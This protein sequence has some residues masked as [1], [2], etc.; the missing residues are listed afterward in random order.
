MGFANWRKLRDGTGRLE[1]VA[2]VVGVAVVEPVGI[3]VSLATGLKLA[4]A[5][6]IPG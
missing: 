3:V 1:E 5:H 4:I 2:H 6:R